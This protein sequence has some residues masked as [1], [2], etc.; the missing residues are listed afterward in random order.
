MI[1]ENLT[2]RWFQSCLIFI[3]RL[4]FYFYQTFFPKDYE[5]PLL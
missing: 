2:Q 3:N 1:G 4:H 5:K